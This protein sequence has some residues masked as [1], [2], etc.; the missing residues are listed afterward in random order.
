PASPAPGRTARRRPPQRSARR[1]PGAQ[2]ARRPFVTPVVSVVM[3]VR[4]GAA[5]LREAV[6]SVLGQSLT[7]LELVVVDDGS[8]DGT[9]RILASYRDERLRVLAGPARGLAP[10]LNA[11]IQAARADLIGRMDADDVSEPNRLER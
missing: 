9:S 8:T 3:A 7:E 4:D 6:D 10:S 1:P 11:G 2:P 5:Y